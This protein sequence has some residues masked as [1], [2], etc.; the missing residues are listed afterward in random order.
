MESKIL[1]EFLLRFGDKDKDKEKSKG[2]YPNLIKYDEIDAFF[3]KG[4]DPLKQ[5]ASTFGATKAED[6]I[7]KENNFDLKETGM[8]AIEALPSAISLVSNL[9]GNQFDTNPYGSGPGKAG[10]AIVQG[11]V[12]GAEFGNKIG[13]MF[14]PLG[15]AIG[16]AGGAL[17]GGL[18]S[19][20]A[21]TKAMKEYL[22]K[23]R[24]KNS[25]EDY[26]SRIKSQE[27]YNMEEGLAS[28]ETLKSLRK[29]QLGL[30]N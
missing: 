5:D 25:N 30:I 17:T 18:I 14:G 6:S 2:M 29:K 10:P 28:I 11:T 15:K 13:S 21:H 23:T 3:G 9:K 19:T 22:K 8:K 24:E 16:T 27:R 12:Q 26:I 1:E 4:F 7:N 20:F